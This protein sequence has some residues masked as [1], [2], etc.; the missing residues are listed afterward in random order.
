MIFEILA[1]LTFPVAIV[2]FGWATQDDD[3]MWFWGPVVSGVLIYLGLKFTGMHAWEWMRANT[4]DVLWI[5]VYYLV[6]G[7]V[8]SMLKFYVKARK[9]AEDKKLD[10]DGKKRLF[11]EIF[12]L[13]PKWIAF[14]PASLAWSALSSWLKELFIVIA[15]SL[16]RV[17]WELFKMALGE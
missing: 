12:K 14:W 16:K 9:R 1:W 6:A 15:D 17:Y 3:E 8:W 13:T 7:I 5:A 4:K 10:S 11:Q 2:F